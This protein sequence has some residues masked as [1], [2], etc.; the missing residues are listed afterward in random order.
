M[1]LA[2]AS[3]FAPV[4]RLPSWQA[5]APLRGGRRRE[6]AKPKDERNLWGRP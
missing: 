2:F 5:A 6:N 4:T 1:T 3:G